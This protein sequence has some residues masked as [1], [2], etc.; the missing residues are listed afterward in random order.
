MFKNTLNKA[1]F[2]VLKRHS[3]LLTQSIEHGVFV[4][5]KR[6]ESRSVIKIIPILYR[7]PRLYFVFVPLGTSITVAFFPSI[8]GSVSTLPTSSKALTK[9][10]KIENPWSL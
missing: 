9:R 8:L 7:K 2:G 10:S 5:R 4:M 3:M 1:I 6:P